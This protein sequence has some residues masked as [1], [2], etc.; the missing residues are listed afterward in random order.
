MTPTQ[1]RMGRPSAEH[2][3][4]VA[5]TLALLELLL[6]DPRPPGDQGEAEESKV[7]DGQDD[8]WAS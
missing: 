6:R 4:L 1:G 5:L 7:P 3:S 8:V 2:G